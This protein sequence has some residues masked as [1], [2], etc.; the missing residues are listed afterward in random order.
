M[1]SGGMIFVPSVMTISKGVQ[2]I[3]MFSLR[4]LRGC[5]VGDSKAWSFINYTVEM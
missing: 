4:N 1:G 2:A 5:I 3:L